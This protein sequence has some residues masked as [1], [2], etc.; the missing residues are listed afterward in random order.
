MRSGIDQP[1]LKVD[2]PALMPSVALSL[3]RTNLCSYQ[4]PALQLQQKFN[5]WCININTLAN[6]FIYHRKEWCKFEAYSRNVWCK[7]HNIKHHVSGNLVS[8]ISET[9]LGS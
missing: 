2:D 6:I 3:L 5:F 1:T 7:N 9:S 8:F 4:G